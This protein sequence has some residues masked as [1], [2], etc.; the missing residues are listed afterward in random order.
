MNTNAKKII[1]REGLIFLIYLVS[2]AIVFVTEITIQ[3][4]ISVY[5]YV[6]IN[7]SYVFYWIIR[8]IVWAIKTL[9]EK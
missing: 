7:T 4:Y 3:F 9:K 2:L 8:F 6:F 1:A 5:L